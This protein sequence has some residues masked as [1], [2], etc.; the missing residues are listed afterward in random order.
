[1][2]RNINCYLQVQTQKELSKIKNRQFQALGQVTQHLQYDGEE[3]VNNNICFKQRNSEIFYILLTVHLGTI[4]VN[5]IT[6][7]THF[8]NVYISLFYMFQATQCS[9]SEE[10]VVSIHHIPDDVL[11]QLMLLMMSTALFETCREVK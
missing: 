4:Y 8:F 1:M 7:M 5:L 9:S 3:Q 11:I 10:S 2:E 6:N